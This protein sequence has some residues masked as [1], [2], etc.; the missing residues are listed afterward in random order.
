MR[1]AARSHSRPTGERAF[2][3]L[4]PVVNRR[5]GA[6]CRDLEPDEAAELARLLRKLVHSS[7]G[8]S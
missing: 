7:R 1:A 4:F 5:E 6:A 3:A 8:D 2:A